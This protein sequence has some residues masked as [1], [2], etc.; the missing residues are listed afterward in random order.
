MK[1]V[2]DTHCHTVSSGH[3]YSTV[4]EIIKIAS[5]K[6]LKMV[7]ITDHGPCMPGGP[8]IYHIINQKIIPDQ[9][10]GVTVLKGVEANIM[11]FEGKLDVEDRIL[12]NLDVVIA[13][14]HDV[15]IKRGTIDENTRA[16]VKAMEN[17]NVDIIGHSGNPAFPIH[18]EEVVKKAKETNTI[19][20]INNSS[21][22]SS[23]AGSFENCVEIARL[24][25]A[26]K[27]N[28]VIGSDSHIAFD[29]GRCDKIDEVLKIVDLDEELILSTSEEKLISYFKNKGKKRFK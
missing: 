7:A 14:L 21:F 1:F 26:Y 3:A 15:C 12:E 29:V 17:P 11:D 25:Q 20:E 18:K 9:I 6:R 19:I 13:S 27:V 5:E 24:C 28:I 22:L 10:Y 8:D 16:I 2:T 4:M 23:R